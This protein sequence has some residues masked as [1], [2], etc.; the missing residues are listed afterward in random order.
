M[1]ILAIFG[2]LLGFVITYNAVEAVCFE[3]KYR[4]KYVPAYF[5][6]KK[7]WGNMA[8]QAIILSFGLYLVRSTANYLTG[9]M[10]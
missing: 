3:I 1:I 5:R 4:D 2:L 9:A 10:T 6:C 7:F 8:S